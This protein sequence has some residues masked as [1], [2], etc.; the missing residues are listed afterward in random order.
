MKT[1]TTQV[2]RVLLFI[3]LHPLFNFTPLAQIDSIKAKLKELRAKQNQVELTSQD[4]LEPNLIPPSP[5]AA[6]LGKYTDFPVNLYNGVT[7]ISIPIYEVK[8]KTVSV[9]ISLSYHASGIKVGEVA[10]WVGL[11]FSLNI[12]AITRSVRGLPDEETGGFSQPVCITP[13][14]TIFLL[15]LLALLFGNPKSLV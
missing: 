12:S 9:P 14:L 2:M 13:I 7:D 1:R 8:T 11:G 10:S 6:S 4:V 15:P 5:T 3:L